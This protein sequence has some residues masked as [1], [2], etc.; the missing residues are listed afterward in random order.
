MISCPIS[1]PRFL[2]PPPL[3][4]SLS[5][6]RRPLISVSSGSLPPSP[7]S[8]AHCAGS[9]VLC[10]FIPRSAFFGLR[11]RFRLSV[12]LRFRLGLLPFVLF[13]SLSLSLSSFMTDVVPVLALQSSVCLFCFFV[14]FSIFFFV[15][16]PVHHRPSSSFRILLSSLPRHLSSRLAVSI[17][18]SLVLTPFTSI[19]VKNLRTSTP[20][21]AGKWEK[22]HEKKNRKKKSIERWTK[23]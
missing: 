4:L 21:Q 10:F 14:L 9:S 17:P 8:S 11:L 12:M 16:L 5:S 15:G 19:R 22:N 23:T 13:L 3:F 6:A 2:L 20:Q 18:P 7:S 1:D